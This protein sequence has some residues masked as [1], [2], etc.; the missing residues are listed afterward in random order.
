MD[1]PMHVVGD[2][3]S[4]L[5]SEII[6]AP[7]LSL[8]ANNKLCSTSIGSSL[9]SVYVVDSFSTVGVISDTFPTSKTPWSVSNIITVEPLVRRKDGVPLRS[10]ANLQFFIGPDGT[11]HSRTTAPDRAFLAY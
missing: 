6:G 2:L 11:V 5:Q 1:I 10:T 8:Y 9:E 7:L 3:T 4:F